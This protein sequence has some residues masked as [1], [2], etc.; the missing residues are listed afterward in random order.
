MKDLR[1]YGRTIVPSMLSAD[2]GRLAHEGEVLENV[3]AKV[4]HLDVMDGHFVPNITFGPKV[5]AALRE[6]TSCLLD[7]HLMIEQPE[8]YIDAF[9]E[10]GADILTVHA[11]ATVHL[12]RLLDQIHRAGLRAGVS[13]NPATPLSVLEEILPDV[14]LILIM[15]VNPGFGGQRFIPTMRSKLQRARLLLDETQAPA[16]LEADGGIGP[17]TAREV[18][19]CGVDWLVAGSSLVGAADRLQAWRVLRAEAEAGWKAGVPQDPA[20]GVLMSRQEAQ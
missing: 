7:V 16:I 2:F 20:E 18:A 3:G 5:V 15:T 17:A 19:A 4:L 1:S 6:A 8:R 11:E 13:L 14:D 12:H 9:A 10:A